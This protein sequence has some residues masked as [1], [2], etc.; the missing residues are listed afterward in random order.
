MAMPPE[1]NAA[2]GM[3]MGSVLSVNPYTPFRRSLTVDLYYLLVWCE[4]SAQWHEAD[5]CEER[6]LRRATALLRGRN[7]RLIA[8][9]VTAI[10]HHTGLDYA[11]RQNPRGMFQQITGDLVAA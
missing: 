3:G 2:R 9:G 5:Q 10:V 4:D 7:P 1:G 6:S 11:L 8:G